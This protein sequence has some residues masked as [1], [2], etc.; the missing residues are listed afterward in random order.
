M[1][2]STNSF[3]TY[4]R[5]VWA[6]IHLDHITHNLHEFQ[7]I[8]PANTQIMAVVKADA[9]GHGAFEVARAALQAGIPRLAIA[10]LEEG[11]LLRRQ[12]ISAP[13]HILGASAPDTEEAVI[14]HNLCPTIFQI[15]SAQRF[16]ARAKVS[17]RSLKF[18]LKL[19]T[20]MGRL[21]VRPEQLREFLDILKHLP[22][23]EMEGVF[24]HLSKA[25]EYDK[26]YTDKQLQCYRDCLQ[27]IREA[28]F[29][30]SFRH[31]AN[32]AGTMEIADTHFDLVRIGISLY[33]FY[34]SHE[35][36]RSKVQ[37][38][39]VMTWKTRI[40]HIKTLPAG[41]AVSYGGVF[42]SK[43]SMVV[44]T[45]PLGYADGFRRLLG[46]KHWHVLIRGQRAP[47]IGRVCMD[48]FMVDVSH[49]P[50]VSIHDEVVLLGEQGNKRIHADQMAAALDTI[51]YEITCLVGK[52]VP[53]VYIQNGNVC[54]IESL[55]GLQKYTDDSNK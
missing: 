21:G 23:L 41:E 12:G 2:L 13:I 55:L 37:L 5:P 4:H 27:I 33:G 22:Q 29:S 10:F 7:R 17:G 53:R 25:D 15:E 20:G 42:I 8:L 38:R 26:T 39:P 16:A 51:N 3:F 49:I 31:I 28:G 18:H 45:L 46:N 35:V 43:Q 48:M 14:A 32:S 52:R 54:A 11:I 1:E 47:L 34:P 24:S 36:D 6:E 50:N 40:A 19:D 30:P 9:Y 44:A